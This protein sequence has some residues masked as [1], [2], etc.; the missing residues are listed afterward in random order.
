MHEAYSQDST[1][2]GRSQLL[3]V[4]LQA[5]GRRLSAITET[6]VA[7]KRH[8]ER[9]VW[10]EHAKLCERQ[11]ELPACWLLSAPGMAH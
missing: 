2:P 1:I 7:E 6:R 11:S 9:C 8:A 4:S 3:P 5:C 10:T